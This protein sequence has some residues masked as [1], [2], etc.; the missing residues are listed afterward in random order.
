MT[1]S[2]EVKEGSFATYYHELKPMLEAHWDELGFPGGPTELRINRYLYQ[3]LE[4][5]GQY[6]GFGLFI[7]G[8]LL[9]YM[10]IL[11][12]PH[13]HHRDRRIANCC[14][15]YIHPT[16]RGFKEV[17]RFVKG[18]EDTLKEKYATEYLMLSSNE[19]KSVEPLLR[20]RKYTKSCVTYTKEL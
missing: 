16:A 10:S 20:Y 8:L 2:I 17:N 1:R 18:V 4:D 5:A 11:L 12:I 15:F 13:L 3:S 7:D 6:K 14:C 9:G 19:I